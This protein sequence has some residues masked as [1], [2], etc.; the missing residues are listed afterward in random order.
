MFVIRSPVFCINRH[1]VHCYCHGESSQRRKLLK[2]VPLVPER[3][4]DPT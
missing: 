1:K 2:P 4:H 3:V